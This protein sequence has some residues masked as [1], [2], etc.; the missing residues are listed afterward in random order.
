MPTSTSTIAIAATPARVWA[1]LTQPALVREWQ[2]GSE[3]I[4]DWHVGGPIRFRSEWQ[5]QVFEQWGTVLEVVPPRLLR[6]TLFAPRPGLDDRPEHYFEMRYILEGEGDGTALSISR[7]TTGPG[8]PNPR[9][10]GTTRRA[11]PSCAPSRSWPSGAGRRA[12][13]HRQ[14]TGRRNVYPTRVK[15]NGKSG[16]QVAPPSCDCSQRPSIRFPSAENVPAKR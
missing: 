11:R 12:G 7:R 1:V 15:V 16:S 13:R 3:L 5:G 14:R 2:Y 10:R 6:Y 4:T 8:R 9:R